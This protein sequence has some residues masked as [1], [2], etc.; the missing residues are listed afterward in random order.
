MDSYALLSLLAAL[1]AV[2]IATVSLVRTGALQSQQ[3]RL[4]EVIEELSRKQL[5]MLASSQA[6]S[7]QAR[8]VANL[9]GSSSH[10][11]FTLTNQGAA[12]AKDVGF[13]LVSCP[14]SPLVK[15]EADLKLPIPL[16]QPGQAVRLIAAIHMGSPLTY[17]AKV[18][19]T[20]PD[21]A[22]VSGDYFLSI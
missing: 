21:G 6:A 1:V 5:A 16:L 18:T 2:V 17:F 22:K 9:E 14:D 12:P 4:N 19:W 8:V 13:E 3:L 7:Q 15:G 20:N 10:R 11:W